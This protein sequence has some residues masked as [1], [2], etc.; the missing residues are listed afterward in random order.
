[1]QACNSPID[2]KARMSVAE[3]QVDRERYQ[4]LLGR[5]IYLCH[6]RPDISFTVSVVSRYMHDSRKGHLDVVFHI[7]RYL[8]STPKKGLISRIIGT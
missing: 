2:V 3:E 6:I 1:M 4:R 8:K 5:L 7:P